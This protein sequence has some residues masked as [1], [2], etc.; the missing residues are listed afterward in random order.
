M[1]HSPFSFTEHNTFSGVYYI[2]D[3]TCLEESVLPWSEDIK[4]WSSQDFTYSSVP[5]GNYVHILSTVLL[6]ALLLH[7]S[8]RRHN[9][10]D[11]I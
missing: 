5:E 4:R 6:L 9:R 10:A 2:F 8:T 1:Y 7:S 3:M 11:H